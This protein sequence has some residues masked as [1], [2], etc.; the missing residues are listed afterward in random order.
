M[1]PRVCPVSC[2]CV[3]VCVCTC[4]VSVS[5]VSVSVSVCTCVHV[6]VWVHVCVCVGAHASGIHMRL[7]SL[8]VA[9]LHAYVSIRQHTTAYTKVS[10]SG[11]LTSS[12][13]SSFRSS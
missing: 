7:K 12:F 2:V 5:V 6:S 1:C 13:C 3:C 11:S 10:K 4:V 9:H 8:R